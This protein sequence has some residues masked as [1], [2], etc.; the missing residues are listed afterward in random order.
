VGA[1]AGGELRRGLHAHRDTTTVG[2][3]RENR[4]NDVRGV[5]PVT[6]CRLPVSE[7]TGSE[8]GQ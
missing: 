4:W 1:R 3:T 2:E 6:R 8:D 5:H 7:W